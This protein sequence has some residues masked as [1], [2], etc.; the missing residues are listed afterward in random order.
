MS[1]QC[2]GCLHSTVSRI[3]V[4]PKQVTEGQSAPAE[5]EHAAASEI[6]TSLAAKVSMLGRERSNLEEADLEECSQAGACKLAFKQPVADIYRPHADPRTTMLVASST[7]LRIH[8]R[9]E[10]HS[11][12]S[13]RA[14]DADDDRVNE[15]GAY[16]SQRHAIPDKFSERSIFKMLITD[17]PQKLTSR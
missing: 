6:A 12:I 14:E 8:A 16:S 7:T 13:H 2:A 11:D 15:N 5:S 10:R 3:T 17:M 1:F 9:R 4:R